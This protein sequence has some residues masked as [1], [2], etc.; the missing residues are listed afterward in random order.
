MMQLSRLKRNHQAIVG[1]LF[2]SPSFIGLLIFLWGPIGKAAWMSLHEWTLLS[3]PRFIGFKNFTD[4]MRDKLFYQSLFN[5]FYFTAICLLIEVGLALFLAALLDRK[6]RGIIFFRTIYFSPFVMTL[7]V[8]S[9][10]WLWMYQSDVGLINN[11]LRKI[12]IQGPTWLFDMHWSMIGIVIMTV[13]KWLGYDVVLFLAGF[14][15][16]PK[17]YYEAARIDGA[18]WWSM[19]FYITFPLLSPITFFV[20]VMLIIRSL[21]TFDQVYIM[22]QGGPANST[23]T[24]A[25]VIYI[26]AFKF[27]RMGY[28]TSMAWILFGL[29]LVIAFI[30]WKVAKK[31]V[32]TYYQR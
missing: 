24:I 3:P 5:T 16:I 10:V 1:Y 13:W 25:Y 30:Q 27:G 2:I 14:Q 7:V 32:F 23:A 21:Q 18:N 26:N 11:L 29:I 4:L 28:A 17:V 9:V 19:F 22:T 6:I 12:G 15:G 20:I 8:A 31:W